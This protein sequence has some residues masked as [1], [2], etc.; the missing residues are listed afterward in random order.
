M[1]L[2]LILI[3]KLFYVSSPDLF[4]VWSDLIMF[5]SERTTPK[6]LLLRISLEKF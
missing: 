4:Y 5:N 1:L 6:N 3:I 2:H